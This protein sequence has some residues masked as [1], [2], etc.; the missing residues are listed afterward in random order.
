MAGV[1]IGTAFFHRPSVA[2]ND[3]GLRMRLA[4]IIY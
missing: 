1:G 4:I 2:V 3:G